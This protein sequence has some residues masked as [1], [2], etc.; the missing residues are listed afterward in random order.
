MKLNTNAGLALT[1]LALFSTNSVG[2]TRAQS[3][4]LAQLSEQI[5]SGNRED[6]LQAVLALSS[7][8]YPG[9]ASAISIALTDRDSSIRAAAFTALGESGDRTVIGAI[10]EALSRE[11]SAFSRK[12]AIYA[13]GRLGGSPAVI[14]IIEALSDRDSEVRG[15]A[16]VALSANP[17]QA[18]IEPLT[19]ALG[20][21]SGFVRARAAAALGAN[22]PAARNAAARLIKLLQ[23]DKDHEVKREAAKA[24]GMI[25]QRTALPALQRFAQDADPYLRQAAVE[26]IKRLNEID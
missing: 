22:G 11:K 26:A 21:G 18:A 25:G 23:S 4:T 9:T 8:K 24:L 13:L 12:S 17:D 15:A 6:R 5:R 20:D 14:R 19:R 1:L 3:Q 7:L 10:T 16:V 2:Q